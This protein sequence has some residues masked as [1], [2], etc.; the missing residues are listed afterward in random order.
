MEGE[1]GDQASQAQEPAALEEGKG[2]SELYAACDPGKD[3]RR[4]DLCAQW[5]AADSAAEAALWT[6]WTG[7][8]TG[9][10]LGVGFVTMVA[11]IAAAVFAAFASGHT[12]RSADIADAD[13]RPWL[14]FELAFEP[15]K[16]DRAGNLEIR[17]VLKIRNIG[18]VPASNLEVR[19]EKLCLD[20]SVNGNVTDA[21]VMAFLSAD[22]PP[23]LSQIGVLPG[24]LHERTVVIPFPKAGFHVSEFDG[25]K[26]VL[27]L[28]VIRADY[29]WGD[30][31]RRGRTGFS[32]PL[33]LKLGRIKKC[34]VVIDPPL[35]VLNIIAGSGELARLT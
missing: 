12:K 20:T 14:D 13:L 3:N 29:S 9:G 28:L 33:H 31:R 19:F 34:A 24:G 15:A 35:K 30:G 2:G 21:K 5:K 6:R 25:V 1:A 11:A 8:F 23:L 32:Y 4:S 10:G 7:I 26:S 27:P 17:L 16:I 18:K 22:A